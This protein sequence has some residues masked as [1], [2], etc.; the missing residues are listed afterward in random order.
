MAKKKEGDLDG[1]GS[2]VEFE[3]EDGTMARTYKSDV[4]DEKAWKELI[5]EKR[6]EGSLHKLIEQPMSPE[7]AAS[8]VLAYLAR[9]DFGSQPI[10]DVRDA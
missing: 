1:R 9:P 10:A 8:R 7:E 2:F 5:E 4:K 6:K 3:W